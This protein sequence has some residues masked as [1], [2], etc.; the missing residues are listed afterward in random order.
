MASGFPFRSK[1]ETLI[2]AGDQWRHY[3]A[4][5]TQWSFVHNIRKQS[6]VEATFAGHHLNPKASD[7]TIPANHSQIQ[8]SSESEL[9]KQLGYVDHEALN[10]HRLLAVSRVRFIFILVKLDVGIVDSLCL[11]VPALRSTPAIR[12][13]RSV[14][15]VWARQELWALAKEARLCLTQL[16]LLLLLL[17]VCDQITNSLI[18]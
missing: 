9:L 4:A 6:D 13:N 10:H 2:N 15:D 7:R 11:N 17:H 3:D 14:E 8:S 12:N 16:L 5:A 1:T 18:R